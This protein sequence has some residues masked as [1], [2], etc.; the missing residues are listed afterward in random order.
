MNIVLKCYN[1]Q[2]KGAKATDLRTQYFR[3]KS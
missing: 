2:K 3:A 1:S